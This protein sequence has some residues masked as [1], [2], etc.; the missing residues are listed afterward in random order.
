MKKI[1][2]LFVLLITINPLS[3]QVISTGVLTFSTA[4]GRS[5]Q[6]DIDT[7]TNIVTM[8]M[9]LPEDSWFG[10][11]LANDGI[12]EGQNMG[13]EN[14]DAIIGLNT[15][16]QDRNMLADSGIPPLDTSNDWT[17]VSN[18]VSMGIRTIVGTRAVDTGDPEDFI[19]PTEAG[20]LPMLFAAQNSISFGYHSDGIKG[21]EMK[22]L[23]LPKFE[24]LPIDIYPNP[25][26]TTLNIT[27]PSNEIQ[28]NLDITFYNV[29]GKKVFQKTIIKSESKISVANWSNGVYIMKLSS[30]ETGKS[31]T[32]RFIKI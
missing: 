17:L 22:T 25:A 14:D 15:G 13:D 29:L 5:V 30:S 32:K 24:N 20:P 31:I 19:F 16:I 9:I 7:S 27:L 21:F 4:V 18:T 10:I 11:G 6:F 23:D 8:T 2:L 3:S 1:T 28:N 12:E 26:S